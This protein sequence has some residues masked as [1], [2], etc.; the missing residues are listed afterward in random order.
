MFTPILLLIVAQ[1]AEAGLMRDWWVPKDGHCQVNPDASETRKAS[2]D[3]LTACRDVGARPSAMGEVATDWQAVARCMDE[4][5]WTKRSREKWETWNAQC[6]IDVARQAQDYMVV[7]AK[8]AAEEAPVTPQTP[9]D[10]AT[11]TTVPAGMLGRSDSE[12]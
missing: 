9:L 8:L 10:T 6:G 5:G 12:E 3:D 2:A 4:R 11:D 1:A 7:T